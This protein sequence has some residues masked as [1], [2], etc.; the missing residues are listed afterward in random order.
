MDI[1]LSKRKSRNLFLFLLLFF[2]TFDSEAV[3]LM[4]LEEIKPGM[5]GVGKTVFTGAKVED[6]D[7]EILSILK[8]FVPKKDLILVRL[9]GKIVDEAGV[10]EGMSGSPVYV[11][12]KLIGALAY[13]LG[14]FT[15]EPIGGVTPIEE[16][17]RIFDLG[18]EHGSIQS[19]SYG[20][21][22]I[23]TPL[24]VAG[25]HPSICD[26]IADKLSKF[27]F[28]PVS[29]GTAYETLSDSFSLEPGAV[30]GISLIRGDAEMSAIG[31]LTLIEGDR[32]IAFG[33]GALLSG[34]VEMPLVA[35]WVHSVVPSSYLSY[36]LTSTQQV[37]GK[38]TQDRVVGVGGVLGAETKLIPVT[39]EV[40]GDGVEDSYR[41]ELVQY[42]SITP[43]LV[44]W[45]TKNSVVTST[46][47]VGDFT[48]RGDM[49]IF[50][51][52]NRKL[53]L[54]NTFAGYN[55]YD[56]F[57]R[58]VYRPIEKLLNNE[59]E[60]QKIRKV[61]LNVSVLEEAERARIVRVRL[62]KTV[63]KQSDTLIVEV[64]I[65]PLSG[66]LRTEKFEFP[67]EG[68][69]DLTKLEVLVS[70]SDTLI[71]HEMQRWPQKFVPTSL[72]HLLRLIEHFGSSDELEVQL[73]STDEIVQVQGI[74]LPSLPPSLR[75]LYHSHKVVDETFVTKGYT[76]FSKK[77]RLP[78]SI[79]GFES[80][81]VRMEG[82]T[83][84]LEK[85][86]GRQKK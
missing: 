38:L 14:S 58:W 32:I 13:K 56:D 50:M 20:L 66:S 53:H 49:E 52:K 25:F 65:K 23:R 1:L 80:I 30:I 83:G 46:K 62:N 60:E 54:R 3:E 70:S 31:T 43:L 42:K 33:H 7:V 22:P 78:Y 26:D 19:G 61:D 84:E 8:N 55:A 86:R 75:D 71:T 36:K 39:V 15:K 82:A 6:F 4:G 21:V 24:T 5:K 34:E 51:E 27:G 44:N 48:I 59:F 16:M 73:V 67:M 57:G 68:V 74:G 77:I 37:I 10:I 11:D 69:P 45:V 72:E 17:I 63:L 79:S 76:L 28:V 85:N 35:G 18:K 9:S 40:Q 64:E 81:E 12:G 41:Y 29:S 47:S 2:L